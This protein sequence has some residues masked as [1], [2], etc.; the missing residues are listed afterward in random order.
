M[1]TTGGHRVG[2]VRHAVLVAVPVVL[3]L[4]A[5][6]SSGGGGSDEAAGSGTTGTTEP[7][8]IVL[9]A[10]DFVRLQDMTPVRG[11]FIDNRLGHLDEALAVANDPDGG[12]YPVGTVIQ[13]VPQ[14]AM[15]KRAPGFDAD[16]N[17]WEFFSLDVSAEGTTILERGGAE[18]IN[19]FGGSCASCHSAAEP[20]FDFVCEDTHGCAPLPIGDDVIR[21]VQEADPRPPADAGTAD[22]TTTTGG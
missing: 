1:T 10:D 12:T 2:A 11:F 20:Q 18:V 3:A 21:S 16:S 6:C 9:Q 14:E 13:L 5:A 17:D 19:R 7:A 22:A 4:V 8:D 15:V